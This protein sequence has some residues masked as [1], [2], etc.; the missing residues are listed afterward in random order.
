MRSLHQPLLGFFV[1]AFS[2]TATLSG[3]YAQNVFLNEVDA[4]NNS[5]PDSLEFVELFSGPNVPLD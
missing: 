2:L 4:D 1:L 5:V 3:A